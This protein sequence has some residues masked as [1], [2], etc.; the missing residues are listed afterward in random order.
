MRCRYSGRAAYSAVLSAHQLVVQ[1]G[2]GEAAADALP[3]VLGGAVRSTRGDAA[4]RAAGRRAGLRTAAAGLDDG[5]RSAAAGVAARS[6]GGGAAARGRPSRSASARGAG[7]AGAGCCVAQPARKRE[8]RPVKYRAGA[9]IR[10]G[11]SIRGSRRTPAPGRKRASRGTCWPT[12]PPP[13]RGSAGTGWWPS[14]RR[15]CWAASAG[16]RRAACGRAPRARASARVAGLDRAW[17]SRCWRACIRARSRP[18]S[19]R[20][21]R[22]SL[23]SEAYICSAVP[24]KSAP[25]AAGEERV[26]AEQRA[27]PIIGDVR[28]RVAGDVEHGELDAE[29]RDA[30]PCRPRA[31]GWVSVGIGSLRGP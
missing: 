14:P 13:A 27:C 9:V 8:Q 24:S 4:Q 5:R 21:A 28:A 12:R 15:A 23:S 22:A 7:G 20:A 19:R 3:Q 2:H 17:R 1:V 10:T 6:A 26:A 29:L 16:P 31:T 18:A 11:S 25:A 30:R